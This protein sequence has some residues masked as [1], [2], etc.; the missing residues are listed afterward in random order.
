[1]IDLHPHPLSLVN[2]TN[3]PVGSVAYLL[4]LIKKGTP[5]I[6][7]PAEEL[8]L[9]HEHTYNY[10]EQGLIVSLGQIREESKELKCLATVTTTRKPNPGPLHWAKLSITSSSGRQTFVKA[11]EKR[12]SPEQLEE[13]DFSAVLEYVC[14]KSFLQREKGD[15]AKDATTMERTEPGTTYLLEPFLERDSMS[16]L[17]G[18]GK[19]GKSTL[20][21]AM[22]ISIATGEP[23]LGPI[24]QTL[25]GTKNV[26]LY[27]DWEDSERVYE[28][29][30]RA[31]LKAA[32]VTLPPK[33][34]FYKS[35]L[36]SLVDAAPAIRKEI[37]DLGVTFV[38]CDS[39]TMA[40]KGPPEEAETKRSYF[41]ALNSFK[42]SSQSID[43]VSKADQSTPYGS[44]ATLNRIRNLWL[45][46]K[47]QEEGA[48]RITV[49]LN[50]T[51]GN[52]SEQRKPEGFHLDFTRDNLG[53]LEAI[54]FSHAD[55]NSIPE[56]NK[57]KPLWIKIRSI[58]QAEQHPMTVADIS[59]VLE[60]TFRTG[61]RDQNIR[62]ELDRHL[63]D[64]FLKKKEGSSDYW[65]IKPPTTHDN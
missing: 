58:L 13:I 8:F 35:V 5:L 2:P 30:L 64:H 17:F 48:G 42:V 54:E 53:D 62:T 59:S 3:L 22:G 32:N 29:R 46:D 26:V 23:I 44:V 10:F 65:S 14:H 6:I 33:T 40:G 41:E 31:I 60:D 37:A 63:Q 11:L 18:P 12:C 15:P 55:P 25:N 1:V 4:R 9:D 49:S 38:I 7:T 36:T 20:A 43:H 61:Y 24:P 45:V 27:L 57:D 56:L 52:H 50:H 28:Q 39:V 47:A 34:M 16:M 51:A 21:L 19:R